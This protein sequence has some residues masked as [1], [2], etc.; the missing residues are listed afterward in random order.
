MEFIFAIH[1][2]PV[3]N[4]LFVK[5]IRT[6]VKKLVYHALVFICSK[7]SIFLVEIEFLF[8][9]TIGHFFFARIFLGVRNFAQNSVDF[10]YKS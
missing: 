4:P 10:F 7:F 5:H 6:K 8:W 3:N 9:L 1:S 2:F